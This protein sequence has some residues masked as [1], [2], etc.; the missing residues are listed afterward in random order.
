MWKFASKKAELSI[1]NSVAMHK[2]FVGQSDEI[3]WPI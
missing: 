3:A 2:V 1:V